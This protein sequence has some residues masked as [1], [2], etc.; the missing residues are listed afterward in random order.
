M[1]G[2]G[3]GEQKVLWF[4]TYLSGPQKWRIGRPIDHLYPSSSFYST[5]PLSFHSSLPFGILG[6]GERG[7]AP[8]EELGAPPGDRGSGTWHAV[9]CTRSL[10]PALPLAKYLQTLEMPFQGRRWAWRFVSASL[11]PLAGLPHRGGHPIGQKQQTQ[12]IQLSG[13]PRTQTILP[14]PYNSGRLWS[15]VRLRHKFSRQV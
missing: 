12:K 13:T 3:T 6:M 8:K 4:E 11:E 15:L 14:R 2:E 10:R 7:A 1:E 9:L 5:L